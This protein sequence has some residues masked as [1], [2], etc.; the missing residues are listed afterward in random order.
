[1]R[2][3]TTLAAAWIA[4]AG[5]AHAQASVLDDPGFS[6]TLVGQLCVS[7]SLDF[8][9]LFDRAKATAGGADLP[10]VTATDKVAMYGNPGGA[11]LVFTREIDAMACALNI[12]APAGSQAYYEA[13]K[14]AL[15]QRIGAVYPAALSVDGNKPSPHEEKHDWVFSAPKDRHFAVTLTWQVEDGVQLGVGYRQVYE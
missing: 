2:R 3:L 10:A 4:C 5:S 14:A 9:A 12:P 8:A 6:G 7:D 15:Q 11:N 13:L 1:M